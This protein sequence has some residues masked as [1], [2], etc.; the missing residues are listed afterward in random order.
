VNIKNNWIRKNSYG[1]VGFHN[2]DLEVLGDSTAE[3]Y[4]ET[5]FIGD[6]TRCQCLFNFASFP[7]EFH[8]NVI[9][10]TIQYSNQNHPFIK[11]VDYDELM[12][13]TTGATE[14]MGSPYLDVIQNCWVNDTNPS[15][16]LYPEGAYLW[17]DPWCPGGGGHLK[18]EDIAK[19]IYY[20]AYNDIYDSSYLAAES[21]FKQVIAEYPQS[22]Y[23]MASLKGLY[24]LNPALYDSNYSSLKNYCDSLAFLPGDSLLGKT[25]EWFS[26][27]CN[28][29]NENYQ[30][31][32]NSL[33][34]ILAN[35]GTYADSVFALIDLS[36]IYSEMGDSSDLKQSLVTNNPQVIPGSYKQFIAQR[37]EWIDLLLKSNDERPNDIFPPA[38][39]NFF[40]STGEITSVF[41]NPFQQQFTFK[42]ELLKEG[43]LEISVVS[44]IGQQVLNLNYGRK[45]AGNYKETLSLPTVQ[46]GILFLVLR[47]DGAIIDSKKILCN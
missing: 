40:N 18:T 42:I 46:N 28:I 25:A 11:T 27:R 8:W 24:A 45:S 22:K 6:N 35:P 21:E 13:D 3:D 14:W 43:I 1:L 5:Q 32:V 31:A 37:K 33:D 17:Q 10:D 38:N 30:Q 20:Q 4:S 2:S 34:S 36:E 15:D 41:P 47:L 16:R 26:I 23:A 39:D 19:S 29:E 9:R 7:T 12:Q 44:T